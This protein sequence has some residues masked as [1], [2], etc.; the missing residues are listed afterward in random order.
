MGRID[1]IPPPAV[2]GGGAGDPTG[3]AGGELAG[4]YPNP[5]VKATHSGS[6]HH[7]QAHAL[8]GADHSGAI[9]SAQHGSLASGDLHPEYLRKALFSAAGDI[10]YLDGSGNVVRL[11]IGA[12]GQ[13]LVV[14]TTLSG[15]LKWASIAGGGGGVSD[16]SL[17][18]G[19]TSDQHHPL[20]HAH[21]SHTGIG[22]N[23]HHNQAHALSGAD[24]S[25]AI[26]SAQHPVIA[27]GDMHTEYLAKALGVAK[28]DVVVYNGS[29]FVR[30][31]VGA[32]G[33]VL[34]A[35]NALTNGLGWE[36]APG[37]SGG[38]ATTLH[39]VTTQAEA[40]LS[41]ETPI[42]SVQLRSLHGM[43]GVVQITDTAFA[44]GANGG[45]TGDQTTEIQAAVDALPSTGGTVLVPVG[46]Y[47]ILGTVQVQ[48]KGSVIFRGL[49]GRSQGAS[50]ST[51]VTRGG[52]NTAVAC[53][54]GGDS[55]ATHS[56]PEFYNL[57]FEDGTIDD[58]TTNNVTAAFSGGRI[59][60]TSNNHPFHVGDQIFTNR[61]AGT[62]QYRALTVT[63]DATGFDANHFGGT[64]ANPGAASGTGITVSL[65]TL[66]DVS[67]NML[68]INQ[69]TR[70]YVER[71][72]FF[73][74]KWG[75]ALIGS[76][77]DSW[78]KGH[79][80]TYDYCGVG[81]K[82][83]TT[84]GQS[85]VHSGGNLLLKAGQVGFQGPD[86]TD[87]N[88]DASH[89]D[90]AHFRAYGQKFDTQNT[91]AEGTVGYE[92]KNP[93]YCRIG[94]FISFEMEGNCIGLY[95]G[96]TSGRV[97]GSVGGISFQHNE[98]KEG[99]CIWL[100]GGVEGLTIEANQAGGAGWEEYVHVE[101]DATALKIKGGN[102]SS[103]TRPFVIDTGATV[104][105]ML[106]DSFSLT[107]NGSTF[108]S[109]W[110]GSSYVAQPNDADVVIRD[111][112]D[113]NRFSNGGYW[114]LNGVDYTELFSDSTK[115][116]DSSFT[117]LGGLGLDVGPNQVFDIEIVLF[118]NTNSVADLQLR[119]NAIPTGGTIQ[120]GLAA[121]TTAASSASATP[122]FAMV[123]GNAAK[124][125]GG[126][127]AG[128]SPG[129]TDLI[130]TIRGVY[131]GG[132]NGGTLA[133]QWGQNTPDAGQSK[134]YG[135]SYRVA[136]RVR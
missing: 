54:K 5:T 136:K 18:T 9:S 75:L 96:G 106:I 26:S 70:W 115:N 98:T 36:D 10:I 45:D 86:P 97:T 27:S 11:P 16:H 55:I 48:G 60:F 85:V 87:S 44:G 8:S 69:Q 76:Q 61:Q 99:V 77:D 1:I 78:G 6:P 15:K 67:C 117:T 62:S 13:A 50:G 126:L 31:P 131:R 73:G 40:S 71:C 108:I 14:D 123:S 121:L 127:G 105:G 124:T 130:A 53:S 37:A 7:T 111:C 17:L 84:G 90:A 24:H 89:D 57:R 39:F 51:F 93:T 119:F 112:Y 41:N 43:S 52:G 125:L 91:D 101:R 23:D 100:A 25:G 49:G 83:A 56:G 3:A 79:M 29:A 129:S 72:A 28:G 122:N 30:L 32:N 81:F 42:G 19:V 35:D 134:I 102:A 12:T 66:P 59:L 94:P 128:G 133:L 46:R 95:L 68:T 135:T 110:N 65:N 47:R 120:W 58:F 118:Y 38:A 103:V 107:D 88:Y 92:L 64:H 22:A 82:I 80:N 33:K 34:T 21:G 20:L 132:A 4:N 104:T 116:N 109:G 114:N 2:T 63:I 74:A 113:V